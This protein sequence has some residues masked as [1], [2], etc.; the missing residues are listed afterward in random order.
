MSLQELLG[1]QWAN[2]ARRETS[3]MSVPPNL[4]FV[5]V[6]PHVSFYLFVS[7]IW[8]LPS[9]AALHFAADCSPRKRSSAR[10]SGS[11]LT[12]TTNF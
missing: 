12:F 11:Q 7:R 8:D 9:P 4:S 2:R 10:R 6:L 5:T 3:F 1:M